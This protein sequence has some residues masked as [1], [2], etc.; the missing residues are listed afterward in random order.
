MA[1]T[2]IK[3]QV[4]DF[5]YNKSI[6]DKE[7]KKQIGELLAKHSD[8]LVD[9][10]DIDIIPSFNILRQSDLWYRGH[11]A[12]VTTDKYTFR[13]DAVGDQKYNLYVNDL[14]TL[15]KLFWDEIVVGHGGPGFFGQSFKS[16]KPFESFSS[17]NFDD[18]E[19]FFSTFGYLLKTD[20]DLKKYVSYAL[21]V[22]EDKDK[23]LFLECGNNNWLEICAV[24]NM[25]GKTTHLTDVFS[26]LDV[27][28][29]VIDEIMYVLDSVQD[30]NELCLSLNTPRDV[31]R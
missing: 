9:I 29:N 11:V 22:M 24:D 26:G 15:F 6:K 16:G 30:L 21:G 17:K 12:S 8:R 10:K 1:E 4:S 14:D 5:G 27:G 28:D 13:V 25:T 7:T 18:K 20:E 3:N 19:T 23:C 2:T 31:Q